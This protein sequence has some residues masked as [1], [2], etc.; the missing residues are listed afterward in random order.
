MSKRFDGALEVH[1]DQN[2]LSLDVDPIQRLDALHG[3]P[4]QSGRAYCSFLKLAKFFRNLI[5]VIQEPFEAGVGQRVL[6][7]HLHDAEWHG[8]DI[9]A[10]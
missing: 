10:G 5:P 9:R 6:E 4:R 8:A 7:E 1:A 3:A 2:G